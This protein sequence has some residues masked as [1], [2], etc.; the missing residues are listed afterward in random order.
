MKKALRKALTWTTVLAA[1]AILAAVSLSAWAGPYF[2]AEQNPLLPE[3][4]IEVGWDFS[5]PFVDM[6][7]MSISGGVY[8]INDNLWEYQTPWI[9]GVD[10]GFAWCNDAARDVFAIDLGMKVQVIPLP[11][12]DYVELETWTTSISL[13]GY[14]SAVVTIYGE[15]NLIYEAAKWVG[16]WKFEP[17]IGIECH[18]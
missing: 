6:S 13:V 12:P 18:W 11:W 3:A 5:A 8:T 9:G 14:P 4:F 7:N 2:I 16:I 17:L 10:L 15:V 1:A